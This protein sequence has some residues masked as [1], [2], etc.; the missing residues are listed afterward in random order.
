MQRR[1]I[2]IQTGVETIIDLT[3]EEVSAKE[4]R[5][6]EVQAEKNHYTAKRKVE[7]PKIEDQLDMQ[8]WDKI[9][10]TSIWS[11]LITTI[12]SDNPKE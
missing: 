1:E 11:D 2:N 3:A 10:A 8:Y 5:E 9:N 6:V 12:K 4:A 7:Y